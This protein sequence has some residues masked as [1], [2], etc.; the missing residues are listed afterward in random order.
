VDV[1]HVEH[2]RGARYGLAL[3]KRSGG[4]RAGVPVV[5]DSVDSIS[6]L[7]RQAVA[8]GSNPLGTG[9]RRL[10]L[11]RTE[12]YEG[13]LVNQFEKVLVT[14][15]SDQQALASLSN[16]KGAGENVRVLRNGVDLEYFQPGNFCERESNTIVLSGKMSYHANV[17]MA[18]HFVQEIMPAVW[19]A[20]PDVRVVIVGKDPDMEVQ[21]LGEHPGVTVTGTVVDIR[22]YLQC[23]AIAAAPIK[24]GTGIQNKVLEAMASAAPVVAA[25]QA[26]SALDAVPGRDLLIAGEPALFAENLLRL[27]DDP[28]E[29]ERLGSAGRKYVEENHDWR[30]IAGRLEAIYSQAIEQFIG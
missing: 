14:S 22:P 18:T 17:V 28:G 16:T 13:W 15:P 8:H 27:L 3:K 21:A 9:L 12:R 25:P 20:R 24:Y 10:E 4:R 19:A 26:V 1:A 11:G 23:A 30:V 5:W 2:L 7:F 29:R 6:L